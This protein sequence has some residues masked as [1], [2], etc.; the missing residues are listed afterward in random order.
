MA[1]N[2]VLLWQPEVPPTICSSLVETHNGGS[3]GMFYKIEDKEHETEHK[4]INEV[5]TIKCNL[6]SSSSSAAK[7]QTK[8]RKRNRSMRMSRQAMV[9]KEKQREQQLIAA[10][11]RL[12]G[13]RNSAA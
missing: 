7:M 8:P 3:S 5:I 12:P 10:S 4:I 9:G 13:D 11:Q 1:A 6:I 2:T